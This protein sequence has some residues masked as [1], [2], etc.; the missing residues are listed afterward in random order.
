M[1][2]EFTYQ[3]KWDP[4]GF[5]NHNHLF[6]VPLGE[7]GQ[8]SMGVC[9]LG[10]LVSP[11]SGDFWRR[12]DPRSPSFSPPPPKCVVYREILATGKLPRWEPGINERET[13]LRAFYQDVIQVAWRTDS[14]KPLGIEKYFLLSC[15]TD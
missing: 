2:G 7:V 8:M 12:K 11:R 14:F 9:Q 3:P 1:G 15:L 4:I 6:H 10:G 5:E 13:H